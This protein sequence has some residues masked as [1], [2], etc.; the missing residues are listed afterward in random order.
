MKRMFLFLCV[1][2]MCRTPT[3][4]AMT[5][6][7]SDIDW[8]SIEALESGGPL[9]L[10]LTEVETDLE[11]AGIDGGTTLTFATN[12]GTF[13]NATNNAFEWNENSDELIWTFGSNTVTASSGDVTIFDYGTLILAFD[14]FRVNATTYTYPTADGTSGQILQTN[15]SGTLSWTNNAGGGNTLDAAYDQGGGGVG[16]SI[17]ADT[18]AVVITNTDADA[19]FLLS[20]TPTPGSSAATGGVQITSGANSTEDSL[21]IANSGSGFSIST[22]SDL[23]TVANDGSVIALDLDVTG[24]TGIVLQNDETITNATD[25]EIKFASDTEDF[26]IDF[27]NNGLELKS[28]SGVTALA[29]GTVDDILGVGTLVFDAAGSTINVPTDG[30]ADDL[31][32]S[33]TGTTN[34]SLY[35]HGQGTAADAIKINADDG[36]IDIDAAD[37]IAVDIA[38]GSGED[39]VL[40]NTGGSITLEATE[41]A[42]DA[43]VLNAS[44]AAGGIDITS[45]EDIDITTTGAAN[46]DIS[47]TNTGGSINISASEAQAN[48]IVID[49]STDAGGGIDVDF[50]TGNLVITGNTAG[51]DMTIDAD[52]FSID[53]TGAANVSVTGGAGEDLTISQLGTADVSLHLSSAG[54]GTDALS[55]TTSD[56]AGDIDINAGDAVT[57]DAG[58]IV[59]TTDDTA[60]DQFKVAAGGAVAGDA[61]NFVTTDGGIMVNADGATNG[62]IA[63]NAES[64]ITIDA[65]DDITFTLTSGAADEDFVIQTSGAQDNH[66]KLISTG[67][68]ADAMTIHTDGTG[69]GIDVDTDSGAISIVADG[70]TAGDILIDSEDT[71][72]LVSTDADAA[73]LYLHANGGSSETIYIHS[74]QGTSVTEGAESITILSDEGGVGIR[75][76]ANLANAIQITNDGGTTGSILIYNDQGASV[77]EGAASIELLSDDGG[78]ELKSTMDN[79]NAIQ[80]RTDAGTSEGI[81]LHADQGQGAASIHLLS[82]DGGITVA[83]GSNADIS[84]TSTG[85]SVV[86]TATEAV[87]DAISLV[88][89]TGAGGITLNAGTNGVRFSDDNLLDVGDVACDDIVDEAN[90]DI[91]YMMKTVCKT[92][93]LDDDAST[94]DFQF[95]D[96]QVNQTEQPVDLGA[97]IPAYAEIVSCQVRCFETVTGSAS[98]SIDIGT[99]SGGAEILTAANTDSANDI[100]ATGA[101]DGPEV[102]A[103][104]AARNVWINA[105]PGANWSTLD[106]GRWIVMVTYLDYGAVYTQKNP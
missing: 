81:V 62:D 82:D 90:G 41:G 78:I 76:T 19:A 77:T 28:G 55:I 86:L 12:G 101:G 80:I 104:N 95:D 50:G 73:G 8:T 99:A 30:D 1:L 66:L 89:T 61:I 2:L 13:D 47:I 83:G 31:T 56:A 103:T 88:A 11:A 23:F 64:M 29:M 54:N 69:G 46:E 16:R 34:S 32:I 57:I 33:V 6:S 65:V 27:Q 48:A 63:L 67:T 25:T 52:L 7:V 74:D 15:G 5:Y 53:G 45:N 87:A 35:L 51:A 36:G 43:I 92:I 58:D 18:G 93:D 72:T 102:V 100:N 105:T 40:T 91:M 4:A 37:G 22:D 59:V 94:D 60:A 44:T 96:D 70:S 71:L 26:S 10:F 24:A 38:G 68:S 3:F 97:I 21:Q 42:T 75:S 84:V 106:A 20:V 39:Y 98:M 49:A 17:T 79:A 85:A 14:Q 9:D